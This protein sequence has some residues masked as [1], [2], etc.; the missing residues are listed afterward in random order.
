MEINW[1]RRIENL[2][3]HEN[4]D[5]IIR[6]LYIDEE[7]VTFGHGLSSFEFNSISKLVI[8]SKRK[9]PTVGQYLLPML[10]KKGM[11]QKDLA[12]KTGLSKAYISNVINGKDNPPKYKV[13][14]M[15]LDGVFI[16]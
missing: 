4:I 10:G 14:K 13:I 16:K 6:S 12:I 2:I 1:I 7:P 3:R 15:A 9:T 11:I 8:E 5:A